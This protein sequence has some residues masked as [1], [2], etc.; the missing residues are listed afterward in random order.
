MDCNTNSLKDLNSFT[1]RN[2]TYQ[3]INPQFS[4]FKPT[5][6]VNNQQFESFKN[7]QPDFQFNPQFQGLPRDNIQFQNHHGQRNVT[8]DQVQSRDQFKNDWVKDFS[9]IS[10]RHGETNQM[11]Q[12]SNVNQMNQ[13]NQMNHTNQ[14]TQNNAN[15]MYMNSGY[16]PMQ[17]NRMNQMSMTQNGMTE[18]QEL[19]RPEIEHELTD[20]QFEQEFKLL[21][22]EHQENETKVGNQ[23]NEQ[24]ADAAKKIKQTLESNGKFKN[25]N[26]LKLMS[27]IS[28]K[29]VELN[30]QGD[31][32]VDQQGNE[33]KLDEMETDLDEN[34]ANQTVVDTEQIDYHQT[35]HEFVP[36]YENKIPEQPIFQY[37]HYGNKI[38][39]NMHPPVKESERES[40]QNN[41]PDPLAHLKGELDANESLLAARIVSGNQ[42]NSNDW[43]ED[44]SMDTV[45]P[46][47]NNMMGDWQEVYDDYRHD[48]DYH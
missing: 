7:N 35:P 31:K 13:M 15:S 29:T 3:Q 18:H 12:V 47:R 28:N 39:E 4:Q 25:S 42:V 37:D 32:L 1:N 23:D 36:Q 11:N 44:Y 24:F 27:S 33:V 9:K 43:L 30:D 17:M 20:Q 38:G 14:M 22:Q 10:I 2:Q 45:P 16:Q 46:P 21:E 26:F 40:I 41:L 48:D 8:R 34:Q 5:N 19:H 6:E